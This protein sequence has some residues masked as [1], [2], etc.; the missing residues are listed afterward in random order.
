MGQLQIIQ[1]DSIIVLVKKFVIQVV[2]LVT[3][4]FTALAFSTGKLPGL[5]F[6]L[7]PSPATQQLKIGN[8]KIN[9]EIA[10]D[11][12]SRQRGLGGRE[13][14]ATNSGML[15]VY[16][17][18]DKR[19]FW[20]KGVKFPLDFVWIKDNTVVDIIK[21]VPGSKGTETDDELPR[22]VSNQLADSVL[23]LPGGFVDQNHIQIGDKIEIIK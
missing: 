22:Y 2:I 21:N 20:M 8:N 6:T 14:L 12:G 16:P 23:E 19:V 9:I 15:F 18:E 11:A 3:V 10:D 4:I 1:P 7:N 13:S 5:P 17:D